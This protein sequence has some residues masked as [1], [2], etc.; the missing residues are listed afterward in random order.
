[1]ISQDA[2]LSYGFKGPMPSFKGKDVEM[3]QKRI[4]TTSGTTL[5]FVEFYR[6]PEPVN[7]WSCDASFYK[8]DGITRNGK[9][10][11]TVDIRLTDESVVDSV[12]KMF[13]S[14][15]VKM[16]CVPDMLNND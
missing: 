10:L 4:V 12:M 16:C 9:T 8:D 11:F 7:G 6:W 3:F 1:M 14:I 15:Y 13:T 2:L 5:Y